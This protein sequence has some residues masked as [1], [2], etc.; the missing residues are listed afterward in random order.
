VRSILHLNNAGGGAG[1]VSCHFQESIGLAVGAIELTLNIVR[2]R[3]AVAY[4]LV[5]NTIAEARRD[6]DGLSQHSVLCQLQ[7]RY[8]EGLK[9]STTSCASV[10]IAVT[11]QSLHHADCGYGWRTTLA[12]TTWCAHSPR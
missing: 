5:R 4:R 9:V 1:V 8:T 2:V 10:N 3:L 11:P 7:I 6:Y 12:R